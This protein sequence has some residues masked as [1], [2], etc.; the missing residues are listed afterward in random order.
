MSRPHALIIGGSVGGLFAANLLRTI[1]WD[2]AVYERSAGDLAERGAGLGATPELF[3]VLERIGVALDSRIMGH[4]RGRI[5]LDRA[6][7]I[8]HAL[9]RGSR[10]SAWGEL[11]G[12]LRHALPSAC[13]RGGIAL[14]HV[15]QDTGGVTATFAD[16]SRARGDLVIAADGLSSSVRRQFL[17]EVQPAYAGYVG[18]RG[19]VRENDLPPDVRETIAER[20]TFGG[21]VGELLICVP[22]AGAEAAG[23]R[24]L[25]YTWYR[26]ADYDRTLPDL[27]T[28]AEGRC[29]GVSIPPPLIRQELVDALL[30]QGRAQL[31]PQLVTVMERGSRPFLQPIWDMESPCIVFGRVALIGDAA[32]VARP[33]VATGV[34][35]AALDVQ[36]LVDALVE[37]GDVDAALVRYRQER[38]RFGRGLVARGRH[39][40]AYIRRAEAQRND[41]ASAAGNNGRIRVLLHEY[42]AA[43]VIDDTKAEILAGR[44][45]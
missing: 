18:W 29:H 19:I 42:G 8:V 7:S 11:Y 45:L 35:K 5:F 12:A 23:Q 39:L 21:P 44:P 6:G 13:Y 27:C 2:V 32:F 43:G 20:I 33:H 15:A 28:D 14:E 24:R 38:E 41:P 4:V 40:G 16:G 1:G 3:A 30:E 25:H 10:T 26:T 36:C 34:S 9:E 22:M 17:P 37:T 31:A